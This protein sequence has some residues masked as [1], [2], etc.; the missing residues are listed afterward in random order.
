MGYISWIVET[1]A[2]LDYEETFQLSFS[3]NLHHVVE[4]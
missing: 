3:V 4:S 1:T 2:T